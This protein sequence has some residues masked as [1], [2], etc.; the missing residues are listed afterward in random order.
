M[1]GQRL[2]GCQFDHMRFR[3]TANP[4]VRQCRH[5]PRLPTVGFMATTLVLMSPHP[6]SA[7]V[8]SAARRVAAAAVAIALAALCASSAPSLESAGVRIGHKHVSEG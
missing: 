6:A 5:I 4:Q 1:S 8:P 2:T 7:A 3:C